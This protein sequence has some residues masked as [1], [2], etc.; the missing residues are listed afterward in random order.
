MKRFLTKI[1]L[2]VPKVTTNMFNENVIG[3]VLE[4]VNVACRTGG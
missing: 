4:S 2:Y 1:V 3:L